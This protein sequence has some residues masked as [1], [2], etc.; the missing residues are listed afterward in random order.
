[1]NIEQYISELTRIVKIFAPKTA[2]ILDRR[3]IE[4]SNLGW[5]N[6]YR[7]FV[8]GRVITERSGKKALLQQGGS[9][10]S[11]AAQRSMLKSRLINTL[12]IL[13]L[14]QLPSTSPVLKAKYDCQ[15]KLFL[16]NV[17]LL[18]GMRKFGIALAK[19]TLRHA[20]DW[21]LTLAE[22]EIV[23]IL[24]TNASLLGSRHDHEKFKRQLHRL[25]HTYE[26]ESIAATEYEKVNL[27]F[28]RS[29]TEK[30]QL[31]SQFENAAEHVALLAFDYDRFELDLAMYRLRM[32]AK[33]IA[34]R[35]DETLAVC[36]EACEVLTS[37]WPLHFDKIRLGEFNMM[38]LL[39][40]AHV[41][42][43]VRAEH[44]HVECEKSYQ[45]GS[46]NWFALQEN[47]M[48]ALVQCFHFAA[49]S[50]L[51]HDVI[52]HERFANQ[53]PHIHERWK[54]FE[55]FLHFT[56]N[57][58]DANSRSMYSA[59]KLRTLE[60]DKG[61]YK[62]CII[63]LRILGL[64]RERKQDAIIEL[65][66]PLRSY[67]A[68]TFKKRD[69]SPSSTILDLILIASEYGFVREPTLA[70]VGDM[71]GRLKGP[72]TFLTRKDGFVS[73]PFD[74]IWEEMEL[75]FPDQVEE[76]IEMENF[77]ASR[78]SALENS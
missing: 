73:L 26:V 64:L 51:L 41:R 50:Q 25:L 27:L 35:F 76:P 69:T 11:Y 7:G 40:A 12:F 24:R 53:P 46:N 75:V 55:I 58:A 61:G 56:G 23:S 43:L 78:N 13:D 9:E 22:I 36:D 45:I 10:S 37:K 2:K 34:L 8:E 77:S 15:R 59:E 44:L 14:D 66:E 18:M 20:E 63:V 5:A 74:W 16:I 48:L 54:L 68:R 65:L 31:A 70:A 30:P 3:R 4:S 29:A 33:Q 72:L 52:G 71:P 1:M 17:M 19:S 47:Y 49:A 60:T 38:R 42:D 28:A 62:I 57:L 32:A 67:R 39:C 21:Q 6:L